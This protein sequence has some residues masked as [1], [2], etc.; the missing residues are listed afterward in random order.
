MKNITLSADERL[1]SSAREKA[2]KENTSLNALFRQW[3][4]RY[5]EKGQSKLVYKKL[6]K[7]LSYARP[8]RKFSRE[9][10]NER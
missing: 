5:A 2:G 1:I 10:M 9:E 7:R 4:A 6:M 8:G 3:L